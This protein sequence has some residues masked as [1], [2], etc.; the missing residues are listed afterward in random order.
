MRSQRWACAVLAPLLAW[1][2][3]CAMLPVGPRSIPDCEGPLASTDTIEGDF[4]LR[5]RLRVIAEGISFPLE[6]I[7][8]KRAD[9]LVLVGIHPFGARLFT[10]IQRGSE[11]EVDALPPA[12]LPIP[13]LNLLRDLHRVLF[14]A[15][16][17]PASGAGESPL[18]LPTEQIFEVWRSSEIEMTST[19][20]S[21]SSTRS[22]PTD[23]ACTATSGRPAH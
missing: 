21:C 7:T 3:S 16:P 20:S 13:P 1:L 18:E 5:H 12:V 15:A 22:G 14:L 2:L 23:S 8:Q 4:V 9:E 6:T 17:P 11:T 10:L 19:S